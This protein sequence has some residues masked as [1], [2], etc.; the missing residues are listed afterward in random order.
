MTEK[1]PLDAGALPQEKFA[2]RRATD[3]LGEVEVPSGDLVRLAVR[4]DD[5]RMVLSDPRFSTDPRI[6]GTPRFRTSTSD[7]AD[8]I[9]H[10]DPPELNRLR[11]LVSGV[12]SPRRLQQWRPEVEAIADRLLTAMLAGPHPA[13]LSEAYAFP[14]PLHVICDLLGVPA[15]DTDRFR[16][17]SDAFISTTSMSA[18][19][20]DVRMGEFGDYLTELIADRRRSPDREGLLGALIDARD[21]DGRLSEGELVTLV[22]TLIIAGHESVAT[23]IGRGAFALLRRPERYTAL[24]REP[25][26]LDGA[27]EEML[28]YEFVGSNSLIRTAR[29]DVELPSG[30]IPRGTGV[31]TALAS[32]NRDE[33]RFICPAEFDIRRA[34]NPHLAFGIGPHFCLGAGLARLELQA[35]FRVLTRALPHLRLAVTPQEITFVTGLQM[36][37]VERLPVTWQRTKESTP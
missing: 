27:V 16:T 7:S 25:D 3:P 6:P 21:T 4:Y 15:Q 26:L 9:F 19:Q 30:T 1:Y 20:R 34:D 37:R 14:L 18:E 10:K 2:G 17:W 33:E 29:E 24:C 11:R 35:A 13:D 36:R 32:A 22:K 12:L 23:T 28:R 8:A 31:I 5:V